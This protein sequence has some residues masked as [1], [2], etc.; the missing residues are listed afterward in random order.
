ME[1]RTGSGLGRV[2]RFQGQKS[3]D[4]GVGDGEVRGLK[5]EGRAGSKRDLISITNPKTSIALRA[6]WR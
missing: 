6:W 5:M 4:Q 2:K 1:D 3:W